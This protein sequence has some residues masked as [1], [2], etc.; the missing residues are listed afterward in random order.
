MVDLAVLDG[1]FVRQELDPAVE[2]RHLLQATD[3][4]RVDVDHRRGLGQRQAECLCLCVAAVEHALADGV[5]HFDQ[6]LVPLLLAH[7]A[8]GH[9]GVDQDLDVDLVVRAVDARD[10][11]SGVGVDPAAG[12]FRSAVQRIL[13]PT[14]L[15][16][17]Q[18]A[19]LPDDLA[20]KLGAV[21]SKGIVGLVTGV[22]V[23][24][25]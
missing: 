14:Q 1:L 9:D 21:G 20:A 19:A 2:P 25:C 15:S 18:V 6:Q 4:A 17:A 5:G 8:V 7:A 12:L 16:Q 22:R 23:R 3:Q 11:V 24:L 10:V 13:D